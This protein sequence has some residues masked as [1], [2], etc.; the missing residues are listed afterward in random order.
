MTNFILGYYGIPQDSE[1]PGTKREIYAPKEEAMPR[2]DGVDRTVV[3]NTNLSQTQITNTQR[4]NE[5]TKESYRN[6]DIVP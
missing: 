6:P 1:P 3:R 5:R 2:G 4:H